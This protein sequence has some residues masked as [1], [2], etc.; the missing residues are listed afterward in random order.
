MRLDGY[1]EQ[2]FCRD[3]QEVLEFKISALLLPIELAR[4]AHR[5]RQEL[6]F[7]FTAL[8]PLVERQSM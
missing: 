8:R 7:S 4:L 5:E 6:A 1:V 2:R 3:G